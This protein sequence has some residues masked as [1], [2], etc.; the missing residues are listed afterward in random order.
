MYQDHINEAQ[1]LVDIARLMQ[2]SS[3]ED[4]RVLA[5]LQA[6]AELLS[7]LLDINESLY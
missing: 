6:E 3:L 5:L 4:A 2:S 1:Q 7:A